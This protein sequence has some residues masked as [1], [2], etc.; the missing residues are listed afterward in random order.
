MV[1]IY[2]TAVGINISMIVSDIWRLADQEVCQPVATS[3]GL[4]RPLADPTGDPPDPLSI[5]FR[6]IR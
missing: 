5:P 4:W 1:V 6:L 3:G 2:K